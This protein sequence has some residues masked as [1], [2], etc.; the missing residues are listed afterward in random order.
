MTSFAIS[1]SL[2]GPV[3]ALLCCGWGSSDV[4][5]TACGEA[6]AVAGEGVGAAKLALGV[7]LLLEPTKPLKK[8]GNLFRDFGL[9]FENP[10]NVLL[11][12]WKALTDLVLF[13]ADEFSTGFEA[14]SSEGN[15]RGNG[16]KASA[17]DVD[18]ALF[19]Q[20]EFGG[21]GFEVFFASDGIV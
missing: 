17:S 13:R 16:R 11:R 14:S 8:L 15:S 9:L 19:R 1:T 6:V 5:F 3:D 21:L 18:R 7:G 4:I 2:G 10:V 20:G 12:R